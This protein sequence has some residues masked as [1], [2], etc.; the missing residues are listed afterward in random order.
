MLL[1]QLKVPFAWISGQMAN[2]HDLG[3]KDH[4]P[5][6]SIKNVTLDKSSQHLLV[7]DIILLASLPVYCLALPPGIQMLWL[8][9]PTYLL[10]LCTT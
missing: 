2:F 4:S 7:S 10:A 8:Q 5:D 3:L 1:N 9:G 6:H